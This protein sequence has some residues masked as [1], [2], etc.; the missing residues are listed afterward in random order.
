MIVPAELYINSEEVS[1][2]LAHLGT[3]TAQHGFVVSHVHVGGYGSHD[4]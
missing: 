2:D 4:I 1:P 3:A